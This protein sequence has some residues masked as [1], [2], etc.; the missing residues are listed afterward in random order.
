MKKKI[1]ALITVLLL[2]VC[3]ACAPAAQQSSGSDPQ[4]NLLPQNLPESAESVLAE[5]AEL[6]ATSN[7][8]AYS[9]KREDFRPRTEDQPQQTDGAPHAGTAEELESYQAVLEKINASEITCLWGLTLP[10]DEKLTLP[11]DAQ[12]AQEMLALICTS[13]PDVYEQ[14]GNPPT[15]G[16]VSWLIGYGEGEWIEIGFNGNWLTVFL[17]GEEQSWIFNGEKNANDYYACWWSLSDSL[18]DSS[19]QLRPMVRVNGILYE[20]KGCESAADLRCGVMDGEITSSVAS[21]AIPRRENQSNFGA[22]YS[23]QFAD[24]G[25]DV[26]CWQQWL[27]FEPAKE[28]EASTR[29]R[30]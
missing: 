22:G 25:I 1:L 18:S 12:T 15:G 17:P 23:Y 3:S 11:M 19:E 20:S 2:F 27:H 8:E 14:L 7:Y 5:N 29:Q 26:A 6:V 10:M 28:P 13:R 24:D 16:G 9:R 21:S 30:G 4:G